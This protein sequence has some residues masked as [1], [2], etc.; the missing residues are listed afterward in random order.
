MHKRECCFVIW[1]RMIISL[2]ISAWTTCGAQAAVDWDQ[3]RGPTRDGKIAGFQAPGRWPKT[4]TPKW[5][6][7]VGEGHASPL[8]IG[9]SAYVFARQGEN[10]VIRRLDLATGRERWRNQYPA[11]YE[12]DPAARGHGKGPKSTPAYHNGKLY[13]FGISGILSCLDAETGRVLWRHDFSKQYRSAAPQ[14]G[15]AMSPLV[16]NGMVIA[17]VGGPDGGALT[18]FDARTGR[19]R[20]RWAEDGPAYASPIAV[21]LDGVRQIVTQTQRYCIG[22][23]ADSGRL[24]WRIPFTTPYDQN[25]VT[26]VAV[27][28][29]L[30][31][32]GTQQ[33]TFACRVRR[34]GARWTTEK[35][36]ETRDATLYMSTPVASGSRLYGLSERRRGQMFSLHATTGKLLWTNEGRFAENAALYDGGPVLLVLTTEADLWVFQKRGDTLTPSARYN[37][38][39]SPTWASPAVQGRRILI[40]DVNSLTRWEIP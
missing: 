30:V 31:F 3:W 21:T 26:P 6:V 40:K 20:W 13:T 22:L 33:P 18:A 36:W 16:E 15:T 12:M 10:E 14:F 39:D 27:G 24:L 32:G 1:R 5:K 2:A 25:C 23:S 29:L 9:D 38:A 37:V 34:N 28:S 8:A 11:P 17:H 4:L 35:V 19:A 7:T